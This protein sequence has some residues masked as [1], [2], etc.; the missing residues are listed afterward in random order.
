MIDTLRAE[1]RK[2]VTTR[3]WWVLVLAM[4]VYM[5]FIAG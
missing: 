3:I 5:A 2:L 4:V 1:Y